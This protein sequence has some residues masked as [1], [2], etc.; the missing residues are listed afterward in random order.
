MIYRFEEI[1]DYNFLVKNKLNKINKKSQK[2]KDYKM[3]LPNAKLKI[4][5]KYA[6]NISLK[7]LERICKDKLNKFVFYGMNSEINLKS[8]LL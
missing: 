5:K 3:N 1:Y 7:F 6:N 2:Y 4:A 8:W